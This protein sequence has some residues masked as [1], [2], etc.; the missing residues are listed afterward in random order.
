MAVRIRMTLLTATLAAKVGIVLWRPILE[1]PK[2]AVLSVARG[3][4]LRGPVCA[5][6][7]V[8][9]S[10]C[11]PRRSRSRAGGGEEG[12]E[13]G[14]RRR[15]KR[16]EGGSRGQT[17]WSARGQVPVGT[18][19]LSPSLPRYIA[20]APS[21]G[22][23]RLRRGGV[24]GGSLRTLCPRP[25]PACSRIGHAPVAL[26]IRC[27]D[28]LR[29]RG[30]P[31]GTSAVRVLGRHLWVRERKREEGGVWRTRSGPHPRTRTRRT[32]CT[33][34]RCRAGRWGSACEAQRCRVEKGPPVYA[35]S[36]GCWHQR[37]GSRVPLLT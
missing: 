14:R 35:R 32:W 13:G 6:A 26:W 7:C 25:P 12:K 15:R 23:E 4:A 10:T 9:A 29:R 16:G 36:Q 34:A 1:V 20:P 31:A 2:A 30:V 22:C 28:R 18:I 5:C 37:F 24:G 8:C 27:D 3:R 33:W 21:P 19:P 17:L 11:S